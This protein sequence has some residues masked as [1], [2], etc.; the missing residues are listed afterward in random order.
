[1]FAAMPPLEAKRILF[2]MTF[3]RAKEHPRASYK[4]LFVDVKKAQSNGRAKDD[5]WAFVLLPAEAGGGV[6]RLKR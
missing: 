6:A 5:E 2:R 4:L 3:R 1:M